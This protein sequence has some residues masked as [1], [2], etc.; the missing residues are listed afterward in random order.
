MRVQ[1]AAALGLGPVAC[2]LLSVS[3]P[4]R[5]NQRTHSATA[6]GL[7]IALATL[8]SAQHPPNGE[9]PGRWGETGP[10]CAPRAPRS[11]NRSSLPGARDSPTSAVLP[12][13]RRQPCVGQPCPSPDAPAA[14]SG[15]ASTT[16]LCGAA[17]AP[18]SVEKLPR[19]LGGAPC[20]SMQEPRL[21]TSVAVPQSPSLC[22]PGAASMR[23]T[24]APLPLPATSHVSDNW[25]YTCT[26]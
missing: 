24:R 14:C 17:R 18:G 16:S 1:L 13:R 20:P 8:S 19:S 5:R 15:S 9:R 21:V 2:A 22:D 3:L 4:A 6:H 10:S 12:V 7:R 25:R 11:G 23:P 26:R